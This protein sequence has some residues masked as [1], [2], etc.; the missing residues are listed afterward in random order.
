MIFEL[1]SSDENFD[2]EDEGFF[3]TVTGVVVE[4]VRS[5]GGVIIG[6]FVVLA[7]GVFVAVRIRKKN[8]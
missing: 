8:K 1:L 6:V 5:T 3:S 2:D 7:V 4:T